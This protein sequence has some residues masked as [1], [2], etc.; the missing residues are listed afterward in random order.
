MGHGGSYAMSVDDLR[1]GLG[2]PGHSPVFGTPFGSNLNSV[3]VSI[4]VS[5]SAHLS[6]D[7]VPS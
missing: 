1:V 2:G 4:L 6:Q 3:S 5:V 7:S